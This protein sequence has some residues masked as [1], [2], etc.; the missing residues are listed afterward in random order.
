MASNKAKRE[1]CY[2]Q[3]VLPNTPVTSNSGPEVQA[4]WDKF[5]AC[6]ANCRKEIPYTPNEMEERAKRRNKA[7]A[8]FNKFSNNLPMTGGRTRKSFRK[9]RKSRRRSF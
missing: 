6:Y 7:K 4:E 1:N 9:S 2:K 5:H 8:L 3:C